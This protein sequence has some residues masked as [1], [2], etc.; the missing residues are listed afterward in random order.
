MPRRNRSHLPDI[1]KPNPIFLSSAQRREWYGPSKPAPRYVP[2]Y[3]QSNYRPHTPR[4]VQPVP[5]LSS[6]QLRDKYRTPKPVPPPPPVEQIPVAV[7]APPP[8]ANARIS[9]SVLGQNGWVD[10]TL[11]DHSELSLTEPDSPSIVV[12]TSEQSLTEPDSPSFANA[13]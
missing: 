10:A 13:V 8:V 4:Y 9:H 12:D 1:F 6:A 5:R 7:V 11:S 2:R 3:T